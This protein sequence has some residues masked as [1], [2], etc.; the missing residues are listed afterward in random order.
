MRAELTKSTPNVFEDVA[1]NEDAAHVFEF[2][3]IFYNPSN[4]RKRW[5]GGI[6]THRLIEVVA[7][8][9]DVGRNL[10]RRAAAKNDSL[11]SALEEERI[12]VDLV[13]AGDSGCGI[14]SP[15]M[16]WASEQAPVLATHLKSLK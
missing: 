10:S 14:V 9:F 3:M 16:V 6:P 1:L 8:D 2:E 12:V 4:T 13:C 15:E 7:A 5:A 11:G